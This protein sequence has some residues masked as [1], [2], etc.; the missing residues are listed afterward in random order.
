MNFEIK[1]TDKEFYQEYLQDFLPENIIDIHTHCYEK[2]TVHSEKEQDSRLA[3]WPLLVAD[4]NPIEDLMETYRMMFPGKKVTPCIFP[5]IEPENKIVELNRYVLDCAEKHNIPALLLALPHWSAEELEVRLIERKFN[6]I[7]VYLSFAPSYLPRDEVRIY[8]FL[9]PS[10]L[11]VLN[12]LGL[13]VMLHIPRS[14]RLKDPVNLGQILEIEQNYPNLKLILAHVGRAYCE[15][16]VGDAFEI[17]KKTERLTFDF[18]ANTNAKV[19]EWAINAVGPQRMI[20]GSDLPITRMRMRRITKNGKYLNL[21]PKGLYGDVS[22][23]PSMR[24]IEGEE[25]DRLSFFIYEEIKSIR[26]AAINTRLN[27]GEIEDLFFNNA[28]RMLGLS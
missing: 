27:K 12:R 21:V 24:E 5:W 9:P 22:D 8:D 15:E 23:D 20:F 11:E 1:Q 6:G 25:A 19:F 14:G 10:Q 3:A 13:A 26:E 18:S 28:H 16:D 7:K 17:L 2:E 4:E